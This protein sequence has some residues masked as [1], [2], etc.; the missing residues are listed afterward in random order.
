MLS[1]TINEVEDSKNV[2]EVISTPM[3]LKPNPKGNVAEV[4]TYTSTLA[5]WRLLRGII[6][7]LQ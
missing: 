6:N 1:F 4:K 2:E 7:I 5:Y 3:V